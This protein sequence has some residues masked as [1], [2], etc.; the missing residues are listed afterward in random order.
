MNAIE[1]LYRTAARIP[2]TP[3]LLWGTEKISFKTLLL[4]CSAFS[5]CL[6]HEHKIQPDEKVL[7]TVD[8]SAEQWIRLLGCWHAGITALLIQPGTV[9]NSL[10]AQPSLQSIQ[11]WFDAPINHQNHHLAQRHKIPYYM[12]NTVAGNLPDQLIQPELCER[13]DVAACVINLDQPNKH[14]VH[15]HQ[16]LFALCS[17]YR[18]ELIPNQRHPI[19]ELSLADR[20]MEAL[21][22]FPLLVAGATVQLPQT[23]ATQRANMPLTLMTDIER[24]N[25]MSRDEL[26]QVA[27]NYAG[28]IGI[29]SQ[30]V[31]AT[32]QV[33]HSLGDQLIT[34]FTPFASTLCGTIN[35]LPDKQTGMDLTAD[36]QLTPIGQTCF[37]L[38][39]AAFS[40]KGVR[41]TA[42]ETGELWFRGDSLSPGYLESDAFGDELLQ[43]GWFQSGLFGLVM[44]SGMLYL[45]RSVV[46][47]EMPNSHDCPRVQHFT[48]CLN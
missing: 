26:K 23:A 17:S 1:L 46:S 25:N 43:E 31:A 37:G 14:F 29:S 38:E 27:G 30:P 4:R 8:G 18:T 33:L 11:C 45:N 28:I 40:V 47:F 15:S 48:G 36:Q 10:F 5:A 34:A 35:S 16:N 42:G 12:S 24:L 13:Y 44:P 6:R 3:A 2:Q 39:V 41:L 7:I 32:P 19:I 9:D 20:I 22:T 21:L